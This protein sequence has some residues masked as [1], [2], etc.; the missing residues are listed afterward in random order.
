MYYASI[1]ILAV[2]H[3]IIINYDILK[4]GRKFPKEGSHYKYTQ[5]LTIIFVFYVADLSWG[6]L[7]ETNIRWLA[8]ADTVLFFASMALSVLLWTRYVVAFLN[9]RGVRSAAFKAAGWL[10]FGFVILHLIVNFFNPIIFTFTEEME[11][12]PG[13]AR[14]MLLGLQFLLFVLISLYSFFVLF[15]TQGRDKVH[16][17]AICLSGAVMAFFICIQSLYPLMPFYTI[18]CF[19]ANCLIHVFVEEDEK[20][21]QSK[22]KEKVEKEKEIYNQISNSLAENYEVIYYIDIESGEYREISSSKMYESMNIPKL[23]DNFYDVTHVNILKYVHPDDR[24]FALR[25][26][27]KETMLKNLESKKSFGFK[28]RV[29][30]NGQPRFY[31]FTLMFADDRKHFVLC[32]KDI[33][34]TVT[35]ETE[36]REKQKVNVTFGQIAESLA[37]NYDVIYYINI[38]TGDYAG[39]TSQNLYGKLKVNESGE[40]FFKVAREN[41]LKIIHPH[42]R[43]RILQVFDKD[44]LLSSLESKKQVSIEYRMIIDDNP[45]HTRMNIRKSSDGNHFIICVENIDDEVRKE[46]EH[47]RVLNTEKELARRDELTSTR[48]KTAFNELQ[49]SVQEN[50][51][52]GMNYLPFAIVVCDLND[53]KKVNDTEGHKAGDD[54]IKASA[55]LLCDIFDH[56]PVFRIGGD[57]FAIFLSGSDFSARHELVFKLHNHSV[58]NIDKHNGPVIAVGMSDYVPDKDTSF[59][60]VF[61]RADKLMYEDKRELKQRAGED[62]I[63]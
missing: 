14:Y 29:M 50:I 47:L 7:T 30:I 36:M 12:I 24:K 9:K 23:N 34:D 21:E 13:S 32:E 61:E 55:K 10:I 35:A 43:E 46:K 40:E 54:Y 33:Q 16:Y 4:N 52:K 1:G 19:F 56:S 48:N 53:L 51:D 18:G 57:E 11:Y 60:E 17:R 8:Y 62:E 6:F 3:H 37:S 22:E 44:Y 31:R 26:F 58:E 41:T 20:R 27:E 45:Q 63:R 39:Y 5:F 15:K 25:M 59:T 49:Q 38:R 2:L 28:Y 42:D